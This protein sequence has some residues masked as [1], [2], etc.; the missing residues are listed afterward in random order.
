MNLGLIFCVLCVS[1]LLQIY[2][3]KY[4]DER[5]S[6]IFEPKHGLRNQSRKELI[7][8]AVFSFGA[9]FASFL[10]S[11]ALIYLTTLFKLPLSL[12]AWIFAPFSLLAFVLFIFGAMCTVTI[13]FAKRKNGS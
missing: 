3:K 13:P 5:L 12:A 11:G 9:S 7:E 6:R 4:P 10:I 1:L 8:Q 2:I